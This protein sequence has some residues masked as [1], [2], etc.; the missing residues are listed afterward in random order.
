MHR[1]AS[2][3][4]LSIRLGCGVTFNTELLA[5]SVQCGVI[6]TL[7]VSSWPC[8]SRSLATRLALDLTGTYSCWALPVHG[9][10]ARQLC[11]SL[12]WSLDAQDQAGA[13]VTHT[14]QTHCC[15]PCCRTELPASR[16]AARALAAHPPPRRTRTRLF[17]TAPCDISSP[18]LPTAWRFLP[19]LS[20]A[21]LLPYACSLPLSLSP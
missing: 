9:P 17:M 13:G 21:K 18:S 6:C 11:S 2:S 1:R 20:I 8:Y 10:P 12:R 15:L 5:K 3:A 7:R 14:T 4:N 19:R 16:R